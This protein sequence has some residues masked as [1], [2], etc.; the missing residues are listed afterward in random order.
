MGRYGLSGV[1][2]M[3]LPSLERPLAVLNFRMKGKAF[4]TKPAIDARRPLARAANGASFAS[5]EAP[6]RPRC[7][8]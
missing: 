2:R 1:R 5:C 4:K 7:S 6:V 3:T 8:R